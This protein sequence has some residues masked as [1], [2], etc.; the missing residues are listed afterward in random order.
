VLQAG[1]LAALFHDAI[2]AA[3]RRAGELAR[4]AQG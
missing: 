2:G 4:Q 1:G 3:N